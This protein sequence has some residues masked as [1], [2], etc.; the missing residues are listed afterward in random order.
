MAIVENY[1]SLFVVLIDEYFPFHLP[2]TAIV[3]T[4]LALLLAAVV[5][6]SPLPPPRH[7]SLMAV[8]D[9]YPS[10]H[11]SLKAIVNNYPSL[12][13]TI[14]EDYPPLLSCLSRGHLR[15]LPKR[16]PY[17]DPRLLGPRLRSQ[18]RARSRGR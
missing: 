10:F 1:F 7:T 16:R 13:T 15:E 14:D 6:S 4:Y 2:L 18:I 12:L 5:N 17:D 3:L 8:I 9:N 11:L